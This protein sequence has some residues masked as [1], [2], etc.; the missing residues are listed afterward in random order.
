LV[1]SFL[2]IG[3]HLIDL[4]RNFCKIVTDLLQGVCSHGSFGVRAVDLAADAHALV[5]ILA[6]QLILILFVVGTVSEV[7]DGL[8]TEGLALMLAGDLVLV[9]LEVAL[10]AEV[11]LLREA[12]VRGRHVR[13]LL[14]DH[15]LRGGA[16]TYVGGGVP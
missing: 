8:L 3:V 13:T 7:E 15:A 1:L 10:L 16:H 2:E 9:V 14:A 5:A 6:K 4:S 11:G 12:V